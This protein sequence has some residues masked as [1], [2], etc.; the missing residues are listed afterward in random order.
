METINLKKKL[1]KV[2]LIA[3]LKGFDIL[4]YTMD[5][6]KTNG[7]KKWQIRILF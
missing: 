1:K 2:F 3:C 6:L 5:N 4:F 7:R